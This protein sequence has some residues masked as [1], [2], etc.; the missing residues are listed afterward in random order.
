[1]R[2]D[3]RELKASYERAERELRAPARCYVMSAERGDVADEGAMRYEL[4]R[5][6]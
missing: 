6:H 1:M 4:P 5:R 3:E 2:R